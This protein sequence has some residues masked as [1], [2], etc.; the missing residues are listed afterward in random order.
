M[1]KELGLGPYLIVD[2]DLERLKEINKEFGVNYTTD[3]SKALENPEID[4]FDNSQNFDLRFFVA[5]F[6]GY[7]LHADCM[8]TLSQFRGLL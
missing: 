1:L 6:A 5:S 4:A 2:K 3:L 7:A 8:I